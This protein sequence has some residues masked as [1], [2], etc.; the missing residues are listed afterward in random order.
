MDNYCLPVE[1][2]PENFQVSRLGVS[3]LLDIFYGPGRGG[4]DFWAQRPLQAFAFVRVIET[5]QEED[6]QTSTVELL[7]TVWSR[8]RELPDTMTLTQFA[9]AIMCCSPYGELMREGGVFLLPLWYNDG[10]DDWWHREGWYNWTYFDVLFE[11]DDKGLVWS[12]SMLAAFNRFDGRHTSLLTNA[13]L[14][15]ANGDVNIGR[16][17][18][19]SPLGWAADDSVLAIVTAASTES[20]NLCPDSPGREIWANYH[21]VRI[22]EILSLPTEFGWWLNSGGWLDMLLRW[23]ENWQASEQ[24]WHDLE[25]SSVITAVNSSFTADELETGERYLVFIVPSF[26]DWNAQY[27]F[28]WE[29]AARINADGTITPIWDTDE[30]NR[31]IF[32]GY[33]GY[34]ARRLATFAH[35]ANT[36]HERYA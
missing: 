30:F 6:H 16:D 15:I 33:E 28:F 13:I 10:T 29:S 2:H 7:R 21:T 8:E 9:R 5:V 25:Q 12:R 27:T 1:D 19:H 35:L 22:D 36:W 26:S 11:V 18:A 4:D 14:G 20:I 24:W 34:R 23:R 17:I 3:S 32:D 31:S